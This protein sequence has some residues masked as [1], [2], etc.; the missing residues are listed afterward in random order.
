MVAATKALVACI[1]GPCAGYPLLVER[2]LPFEV[3]RDRD[4]MYVLDAEGDEPVYR[5]V[6]WRM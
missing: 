3:E 6:P 1:G 2:P 5:Y 4:G